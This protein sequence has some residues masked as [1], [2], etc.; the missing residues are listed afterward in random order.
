MKLYFMVFELI[1]LSLVPAAAGECLN[2]DSADSAGPG[3]A[4]LRGFVDLAESAKRLGLTQIPATAE[5]ELRPELDGWAGDPRR[6]SAASSKLRTRTD[7]KGFFHL[8][9]LAPGA[10]SLTV[11][12][13]N[14]RPIERFGL[15]LES[16]RDLRLADPLIFEPPIEVALRVTPSFDPWHRPWR[17]Q[18]TTGPK[19]GSWPRNLAEGSTDDSGLARLRGLDPREAELVVQDADGRRWHEQTIE[20]YRERP[21]VFV[22]LDLVPV[23]GRLTRGND[24]LAARLSFGTTQGSDI[25]M[26][27]RDD[28]GFSGYLPNEGT[29][30]VELLGPLGDYDA[31]RLRDVEV[32]RRPGKSFAEIEVRVPATTLAGRVLYD[33]KPVYQ[34]GVTVVRELTAAERQPGKSP[35]V[36]EAVT[37]T[38]AEGRFR[39][40]GLE[41][42]TL[43]IR[44][45]H[46]DR[47]SEWMRFDLREDAWPE[48][49]VLELEKREMLSGVVSFGS[50]PVTGARLVALPGLSSPGQ[51]SGYLDAMSGSLGEFELSV[52]SSASNLDLV[53]AAPTLGV[54]LL[55]LEKA[56][57]GWGPVLIGLGSETGTLRFPVAGKVESR[58]F[59]AGF[60]V[61][62]NGASLRL[63][64]LVRLLSLLGQLDLGPGQVLLH[65]LAP[66]GWTLCR[67]EDRTCRSGNLPANGDLT[68]DPLSAIQ[69]S[70]R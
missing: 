16:G 69:G 2:V 4:S 24:P 12:S 63:T 21:E 67:D 17:V 28:G 41:P 8:P 25:R 46:G 9:N 27:S 66:G 37:S 70:A 59:S 13:G 57:K 39:L 36:R 3:C 43:S 1:L 15:R 34:A 6:K 55:H 23:E 5:V 45:G 11:R 38:D 33:E 20:I 50:M 14:F 18:V 62:R 22:A 35:A 60:V 65:G 10:Y 52:P 42:G 19:E 64:A 47:D 68:L 58:D 7:E 61:S 26:D 30:Q 32:K 51:R 31:Q 40:Q 53:I 49:I 56:E 48:E 29:W 54:E 44:A